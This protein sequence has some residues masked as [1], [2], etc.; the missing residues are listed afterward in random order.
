[1]GDRERG[2]RKKKI[3][4]AAFKKEYR[5]RNDQS[6]TVGRMPQKGRKEKT[7]NNAKKRRL[8]FQKKSNSFV[9]PIMGGEGLYNGG[10]DGRTRRK[11]RKGIGWINFN[12]DRGEKR[13]KCHGNGGSRIIKSS[14]MKKKKHNIWR[15]T[16]SDLK[17]PREG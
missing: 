2:I 9:S 1:M 6:Y 4:T 14:R 10:R 5:L 7:G 11:N 12:R 8:N 15:D 13:R 16:L 17:K 3:P